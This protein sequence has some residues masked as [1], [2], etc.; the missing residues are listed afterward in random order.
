MIETLPL[1]IPPHRLY[2]VSPKEFSFPC[3][4]KINEAR[5]WSPWHANGVL[6]LWCSTFP[7]MCSPFGKQVYEIIVKEDAR[8]IGL[9]FTDFQHLTS[10]MED[11]NDL[12]AFL[13]G[14]GDVAYLADSNPYVG[15]VIILNFDCIDQFNNISHAVPE[16]VRV[17]LRIAA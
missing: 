4:E 10:Q 5:E 15:E 8:K 9:P 1:I 16:D 3:R 2:H 17:S 6:G 14:K 13:C 12:I 11:F 7:N